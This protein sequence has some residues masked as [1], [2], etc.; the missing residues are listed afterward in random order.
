[1]ARHEGHKPHEKPKMEHMRKRK[2]GGEMPKDTDEVEKE[3]EKE[4]KG[5]HIARKSGGHVPGK[6][7]KHRPD[8][9]HRAH[10][11]A[12]ADANPMSSAGKMSS[13]PY[14]AKQAPSDSHGEGKDRD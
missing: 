4:S 8:R 6:E 5:H 14:E 10:G 3:E 13:L 7:P 9:K 2:R 11:G 1:M 12:T